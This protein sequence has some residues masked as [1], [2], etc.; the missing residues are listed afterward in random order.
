MVATVRPAMAMT[1]TVVSTSHLATPPTVRTHSGTVGRLHRRA[2]AAAATN[3][4]TSAA[5]TT[6]AA[7]AATATTAPPTAT[8]AIA[9]MPGTPV[10]P[11]LPRMMQKGTPSGWRRPISRRVGVVGWGR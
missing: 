10:A 3:T 4:A 8:A 11:R 9:T 5:A 7:T 2:A 1:P 6:A